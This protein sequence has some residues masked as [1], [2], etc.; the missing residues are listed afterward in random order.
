MKI[1]AMG[2]NYWRTDRGDCLERRIFSLVDHRAQ[3]RPSANLPTSIKFC[4]FH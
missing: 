1:A 2:T 4:T 3:A